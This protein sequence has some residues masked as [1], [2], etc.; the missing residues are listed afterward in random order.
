MKTD[1]DATGASPKRGAFQKVGE[2]L[3]RHTSSGTYYGLVKRSGKQYRRSLKTTDR[4]LAERFVAEF[5]QKIDRLDHT[6]ARSTFTFN[7]CAARWLG[8]VTPQLKLSSARRRKT[9][10]EQIRD[11]VQATKVH[12]TEDDIRELTA[13][14][15]EVL[16]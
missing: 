4:K 6:K 7:E 15:T 10:V 1:S 14:L 12:L 16:A 2:C 11:L 5:R 8:I 9:S 3:Y 13:A